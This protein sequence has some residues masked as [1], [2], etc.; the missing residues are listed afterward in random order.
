MMMKQTEE[1]GDFCKAILISCF[2]KIGQSG[3]KRKCLQKAFFCDDYDDDDYKG[4]TKNGTCGAFV[5]SEDSALH[6]VLEIGKT[7]ESNESKFS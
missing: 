2:L 3:I 7:V 1:D 6:T 4:L 5:R